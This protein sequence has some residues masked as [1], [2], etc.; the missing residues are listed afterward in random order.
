MVILLVPDRIKRIRKQSGWLKLLNYNTDSQ[1]VD[2][3]GQA[4]PEE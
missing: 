2:Q 4:N 1:E 3:T